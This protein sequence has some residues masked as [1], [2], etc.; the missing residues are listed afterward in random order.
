MRSIP[1]VLSSLIVAGILVF[2]SAA[3]VLAQDGMETRR[4]WGKLANGRTEFEVSDPA[5]V[6][7]TVALAAEQSRCRYK[8]YIKERPARFIRPEGSPLVIVFCAGS[9]QVFDVSNV[10]RPTPVEFPIIVRP[11]GFGTTARPGLITWEKEAN[12]FHAESGSDTSLAGLRHI[13]RLE[14]GTGRFVVVRVEFAPYR[15]TKDGW[16]TIWDAPTWS[17][18]GMPN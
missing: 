12:V 4:E 11:D 15:G 5:L 13:Y 9:D 16:T 18:P 10:L 1:S 14:R 6:L 2:N 7:S 8:D 17:F 3:A